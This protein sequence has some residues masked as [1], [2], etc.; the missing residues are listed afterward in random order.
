MLHTL[1]AGDLSL[2]FNRSR[3]AIPHLVSE[4]VSCFYDNMFLDDGRVKMM[5]SMV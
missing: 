5:A 4:A 3:P 1:S 2:V